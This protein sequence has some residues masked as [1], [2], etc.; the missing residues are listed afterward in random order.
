MLGISL[1]QL[2]RSPGQIRVLRVLWRAG[3]PLTGRQVQKLSGL[4]NLAAMQALKKLSEL[5]VVSCRRAGQSN[6]YELMRSHWTVSKILSPMF[7][8]EN[9]GLSYLCNLI[10]DNLKDICIS[11]YIYGSSISNPDGPVGDA[12]LLLLVKNEKDKRRLEEGP[13]LELSRQVSE[14]FNLFLEPNIFS[15]KEISSSGAQKIIR[16]VV[17]SGR[18]IHGQ[19]LRD[20]LSR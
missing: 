15:P 13:L 9:K 19:D 10:S 4:A 12:D 5:G 1:E 3:K 14:T 17:R 16:A 20:L 2:L 11:A 18:K 7:E 6:Q 8:S